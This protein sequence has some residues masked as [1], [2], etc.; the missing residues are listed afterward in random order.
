MTSRSVPHRALYSLVE[1]LQVVG[2]GS[3][4]R[5][6]RVNYQGH[7]AC[8]KV[9]HGGPPQISAFQE[10]AAILK[11]IQGAGGAPR[12]HLEGTDWPLL[13]VDFIPFPSL[14]TVMNSHRLSS[15]S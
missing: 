2:Q 4:A 15:Q 10:E 6:L 14:V 11:K 13:L 3:A 5:A 1:V 12:L 8:L 7:D 9:G